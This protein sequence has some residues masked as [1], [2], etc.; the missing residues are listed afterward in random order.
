[1]KDVLNYVSRLTAA[2]DPSDPSATPA[3]S[4]LLPANTPIFIGGHGLGA[5]L[6]LCCALL[7]P[8]RFGA[9]QLTRFHLITLP[10]SL[11][12]LLGCAA[13]WE[14]LCCGVCCVNSWFG[15]ARAGSAF[16]RE[17]DRPLYRFVCGL[18]LAPAPLPSAS[19]CA[20]PHPTPSLSLALQSAI[21][22]KLRLWHTAY[23]THSRNPALNARLQSG[24]DKLWV[25]GGERVCAHTRAQLTRLRSY[26]LTHLNAL[27]TSFV[28]QHGLQDLICHPLGTKRLLEDTIR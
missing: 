26:L 15:V 27:T 25:S 24:A 5:N 11:S 28:V 9:P 12:L 18:C 6:A 20:V 3:I 8:A 4:P 14:V 7:E 19:A 22:P 16:R 17:T 1:M 21:L 2:P 13:E 23:D 10:L